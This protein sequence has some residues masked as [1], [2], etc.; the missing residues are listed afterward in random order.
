VNARSKIGA[1]IVFAAT[2]AVFGCHAPGPRAP[3]SPAG[4]AA[5]RPQAPPGAT[6]REYR[7]SAEESLLTV[8]VYRGGA[9]AKAGHNHVIASHQLLGTITVPED[10]TASSFELR[11]PVTLMTVDEA[12]LREPLGADFPAEI[13]AD[14]K[15]GTRRNMLSDALLD[16]ER[17]PGISLRSER[18]V[19]I[20]GGFEVTLLV[21]IKDQTHTMTLPV[22]VE[23]SGAVLRA[24]GELSLRQSALGLKPFSVMLGALQ[25]LDEIKVRAQIVA[26]AS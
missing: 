2:F 16:G 4:A 13:P 23:R 1:A 9:L 17:Y 12:P 20:P 8:L 26:R 21:G 24:S 7:V 11:I 15:E 25:V 18:I 10:L 22:M 5:H 14:A 3:A 19:A 6:G